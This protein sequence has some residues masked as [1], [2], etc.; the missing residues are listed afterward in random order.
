MQK[1]KKL[2]LSLE[3]YRLPNDV[4]YEALSTK[5]NCNIWVYLYKLKAL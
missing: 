5:I 4:N 3:M 1:I 2:R